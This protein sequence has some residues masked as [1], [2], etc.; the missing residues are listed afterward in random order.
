MMINA[1]PTIILGYECVG[2]I[3]GLDFL[4]GGFKGC[5]LNFQKSIGDHKKKN[6]RFGPRSKDECSNGV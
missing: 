1:L 3:H 4:R 5:I 6:R 2:K